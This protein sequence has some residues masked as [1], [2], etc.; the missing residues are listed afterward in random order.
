[1]CSPCSTVQQYNGSTCHIVKRVLQALV[2]ARGGRGGVPYRRQL[3][4]VCRQ[5]HGGA[6]QRDQVGL[7]QSM[8]DSSNSGGQE[9]TVGDS[10][11][12]GRQECNS[13]AEGVRHVTKAAIGSRKAKGR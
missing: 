12:S 6:C 3:V 10:S 2:A 4:R 9:G 8:G 5:R 11:N 7:Q 13:S 1:M